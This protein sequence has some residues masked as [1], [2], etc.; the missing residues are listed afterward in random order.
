VELRDVQVEYSGGGTVPASGQ[1]IKPPRV[2]ARALP[3][4]GLYA[5][6][7]KTV[8]L[9]DVRVTVAT[10]DLRPVLSADHVDRL[11]LDGFKFTRVP[12]V[13]EPFLTNTVGTVSIE[14]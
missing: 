1:L 6:N 5:R 7:V 10:N 14:Q 12:G 2:D 8:T 4:W 13:N 11:E 3:V 9:E